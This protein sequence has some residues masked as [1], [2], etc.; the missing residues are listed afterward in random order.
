MFDPFSETPITL[1]KAR[2]LVPGRRDGGVNIATIHRWHRCG[3]HGVR[4]ETILIGGIRPRSY[5]VTGGDSPAGAI[6][7]PYGGRGG[8]SGLSLGD[9]SFEHVP[10][11]NLLQRHPQIVPAALEQLDVGLNR[12]AI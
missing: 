3:V 4:L 6:A 7:R 10:R 5:T 11:F 1:A 2:T 8:R 12:L 9:C